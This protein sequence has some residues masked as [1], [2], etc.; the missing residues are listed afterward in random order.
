MEYAPAQFSTTEQHLNVGVVYCKRFVPQVRKRATMRNG[1][2]NVASAPHR[3]TSRWVVSLFMRRRHATPGGPP[4]A[5]S[6]Q[7]IFAIT[8]TA[9]RQNQSQASRPINQHIFAELQRHLPV[10]V[11]AHSQ[12]VVAWRLKLDAARRAAVFIKFR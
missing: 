9:T 2:R 10:V 6:P 7:A 12:S 1:V 11:S 4:N 3:D 5:E 8:A